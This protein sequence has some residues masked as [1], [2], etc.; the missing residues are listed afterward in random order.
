MKHGRII[1]TLF[2]T[3][4]V[5]ATSRAAQPAKG[6]CV[7]CTVLR[8]IDGDTIE[9]EVKTTLRVRLLDCWCPES[10]TLDPIEKA[11]GAKAKDAMQVAVAGNPKATLFVPASDAKSLL[12]VTTMGRVLGK[13]WVEDFEEDLSAMMV[14]G[15]YASTTKVG[16]LGE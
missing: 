11:M 1:L 14:R 3:L 4:A 9:V 2:A 5:A 10:R 12:D 6:L 16:K 7:D 13:V 8:A 15:G